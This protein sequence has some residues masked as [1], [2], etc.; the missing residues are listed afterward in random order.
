[1][2]LDVE[3]VIENVTEDFQN[4]AADIDFSYQ[5]EGWYKTALTIGRA[6]NLLLCFVLIT[7]ITTG[8]V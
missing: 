7:L 6:V 2:N 8:G 1:M 3:D 5:R 4:N